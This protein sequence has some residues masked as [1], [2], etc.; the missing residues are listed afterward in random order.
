MG[1][2]SQAQEARF[3]EMV[4][5]GT[6]KQAVYDEWMADTPDLKKLPKRKNPKK[7]AVRRR[8]R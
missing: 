2:V 5:A 4:K 7:N 6:L 3:R 1:F 8:R